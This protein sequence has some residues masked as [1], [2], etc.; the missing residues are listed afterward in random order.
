MGAVLRLTFENHLSDQL[1]AYST[2]WTKLTAAALI[3]DSITDLAERVASPTLGTHTGRAGVPGTEG[4]FFRGGGALARVPVSCVSEGISIK[5][6]Y[7]GDLGLERANATGPGS[8]REPQ[9]D[10]CA[11]G[12]GPGG[13]SWGGQDD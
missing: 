8:S 11:G 2:C 1:R 12:K 13:L 7:R 5:T 4:L 3:T 10:L 9:N 6:N